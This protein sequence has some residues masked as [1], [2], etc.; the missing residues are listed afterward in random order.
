MGLDLIRAGKADI[1]VAGGA[2]AAI[3]PMPIAGVRL[4]AGPLRRNDDP[5]TPPAP[6]T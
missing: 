1:V 2:E 6:T 4:H 3:H 5:S